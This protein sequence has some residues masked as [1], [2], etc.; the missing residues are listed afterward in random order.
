MSGSRHVF[1]RRQSCKVTRCST[2]K[3]GYLGS[4]GWAVHLQFHWSVCAPFPHWI[5]SVYFSHWF[6]NLWFS[7][8]SLQSDCK[9]ISIQKLHL[10]VSCSFWFCIK[11]GNPHK[12]LLPLFDSFMASKEADQRAAALV[13]MRTKSADVSQYHFGGISRGE[14]DESIEPLIHWAFLSDIRHHRVRIRW[15]WNQWEHPRKWR[16]EPR[17]QCIDHR[18]DEWLYFQHRTMGILAIW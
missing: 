2:A 7:H 6:V 16:H 11:I 9:P 18:G 8:F 4:F 13:R 1:I 5:Y 14:E 17:G 12:F 10:F 15:S 3:D